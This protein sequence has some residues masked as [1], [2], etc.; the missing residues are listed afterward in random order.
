MNIAFA[1]PTPAETGGGGTH[2][3]QGIAPA[4]RGLGHHV[5]LLEGD[6]PS[7][8]PDAVPVIDGML[9][10]R[11]LPRLD[12]LIARDA[13]V[14]VYHVSAAA[15][16]DTAA[17]QGVQETERLML[18]RLR[19]VIATSRP[20]ATQLEQAF[21]LV[22]PRVVV[23]GAADLPR[24][25][26]GPECRI[27]SVGVLTPRKG[28]DRLLRAMA[29]LTDLDWHLVIAGDATRDPVHA[30]TLAALIEDLGLSSRA[31]LL[32]NP[33]PPA[34]AADWAGASLFALATS[35]EGYAAAV[36]QALRRGIPVVVTDGGE[37]GA[38]VTPESGAV[39]A[40]DDAATFGK[41]LRRLV[42]DD[43]LRADMAVAAW[44]AGQALPGWAQQA[45]ALDSI[46]RS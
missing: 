16:R 5:D 8:P 40:L 24:S 45:Q 30:A 11:L 4:L 34:L 1:L 22:N 19:R 39:C 12:E 17:R 28:H 9:L 38:L 7:L 37:A 36:A 33:E 27:L 18:P 3:I 35:W 25:Q 14:L 31:S 44:Q 10:P 2:F 29:R 20:V 21:G 23:A 43:A 13:A 26:P 6:A 42:F 41:C 15:G 32:V 46:L